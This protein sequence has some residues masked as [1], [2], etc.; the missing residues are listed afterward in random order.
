MEERMGS[1]D[2]VF[3]IIILTLRYWLTASLYEESMN[4]GEWIE[5]EIHS[6]QQKVP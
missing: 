3:A 1:E 4:I 2:H 6:L 5:G